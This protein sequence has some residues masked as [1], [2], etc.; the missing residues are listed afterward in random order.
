MTPAGGRPLFVGVQGLIKRRAKFVLKVLTLFLSERACLEVAPGSSLPHFVWCPSKAKG[1]RDKLSTRLIRQGNPGLGPVFI[2]G[3]AALHPEVEQRS[4]HPRKLS[5]RDTRHTKCGRAAKTRQLHLP[6]DVRIQ[7]EDDAA[8]PR[9]IVRRRTSA[10]GLGRT[11][12]KQR[13]DAAP[14]F[15]REQF[16]ARHATKMSWPLPSGEVLFEPLTPSQRERGPTRAQS[17]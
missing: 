14:E 6:R 1:R 9:P 12:W 7:H 2:C 11:G 16:T 8:Q 3:R 13:L 4:G 5:P 15:V 17:N 10:L